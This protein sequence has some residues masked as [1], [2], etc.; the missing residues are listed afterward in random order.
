MY[1]GAGLDR[2]GLGYLTASDGMRNVCYMSD[3]ETKTKKRVAYSC[4]RFSIHIHPS[5][6]KQRHS[7][8]RSRYKMDD[9]TPHSFFAGNEQASPKYTSHDG[10]RVTDVDVR[11]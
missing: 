3:P 6:A 4:M 7:R 8:I 11:E 5:I 10:G 2:T 9:K 1:N